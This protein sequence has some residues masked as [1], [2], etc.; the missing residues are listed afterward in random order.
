MY[1]IS[2]IIFRPLTYVI[3][4]RTYLG[5]IKI[6]S[7]LTSPF[8]YK[9]KHIAKSIFL[10]IGDFST[11]QIN[12]VL[13]EGI[14][15]V[16]LFGFMDFYLGRWRPDICEKYVLVEGK[17]HFQQ[18]LAEK[19]GVLLAFTH[20]NTF[21]AAFPCLGYVKKI[22]S[23]VILDSSERLSVSRIHAKIRERLWE[24]LETV[25]YTYLNRGEAVS[26]KVRSMLKEGKIVAISADGLHAGK[27]LSVPFFGKKI[28]LPTGIF[29]LS[30]LLGVPILPLFS[31]FDGKKSVFRVW[32]G[33]PILSRTP[34]EAAEAFIDQFQQHL[35]KYPSHWT[36][37]WRMKLIKD[38]KGED[39]FQI[40]SI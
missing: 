2:F 32:L 26:L 8:Y 40:H 1:I 15:N 34:E 33:D 24:S 20:S 18:A 11:E 21:N 30:T 29:K 37:W 17:E 13:R 31:G 23:I 22:C 35:R 14:T 38:E 3:P 12:T 4:F 27:F 25:S 28:Q 39:V 36:G 6:L 9:R 7:Y 5:L 19:R 16:S 10:L